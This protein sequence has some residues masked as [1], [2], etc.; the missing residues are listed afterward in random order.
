MNRPQEILS[1]SPEAAW[2]PL[3]TG[4]DA[5][6]AWEAIEAIAEDL[7]VW[8]EEL[9]SHP[10]LGGGTAGLALF[11]AYLAEAT[12]ED[13]YADTAIGY[14]EDMMSVWES[15]PPFL[16]F[17]SGMTGSAFVLEHL[18]GRLFDEDDPSESVAEL[19][20]V[21]LDRQSW[22]G[23]YDLINGLV[24][25]GVYGLEMWPRPAGRRCLELVLR[26]LEARAEEHDDGLTWFTPRESVPKHQW[27][28]FPDGYYNL[29]MAHGVPAVVALL[30]A[31]QAGG[32]APARVRRLLDGSVRWLLQQ[33]LDGETSAWFP[34]AVAPGS[35]PRNSRLAWCYGDPGVAAALLNGARAADE[36][37][38]QR[39]ARD[40][41]R[42]CARRSLDDAGVSDAG[43]CHGSGGL[44]LLFSR[45]F[46]AWGDDL[47]AD[48]AIGWY[49]H[50]LRLRQPDRGIGGYLSFVGMGPEETRWRPTR[51]F[52]EGAAGVG[53]AL[54]AGVSPVEPAWD[55]V[56]M[57]SLRPLRD[58]ITPSGAAD[59]VQVMGLDLGLAGARA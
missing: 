48:A 52:L 47:C 4:A 20:E 14:L 40:L 39:T 56:M 31:M 8:P 57:T 58:G 45:F 1:S 27:T 24:G 13:R 37:A 19:L 23:E 16:S 44:G 29:G 22:G 49:R 42:A 43:L 51:G 38:W 3:L 9:E 11:F 21:V 53:L 2:A 28:D 50:A 35:S 55:R 12:G 46:Q 34:H 5:S 54:L 26:H 25:F 59:E 17:Y 30:G 15:R 18:R 36:V 32:I 41:A 33:R 6:D 10:T 7:S